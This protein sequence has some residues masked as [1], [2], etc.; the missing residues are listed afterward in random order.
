MDNAF[1]NHPMKREMHEFD[2]QCFFQQPAYF[3]HW[4]S[5]FNEL[6]RS[7][8]KFKMCIAAVQLSEAELDTSSM[9]KQILYGAWP[10]Q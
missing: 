8:G 5:M 1:K 6:H 4:K 9:M 3:E 10:D 2:K 7:R